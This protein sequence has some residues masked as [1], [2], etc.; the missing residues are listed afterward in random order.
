MKKIL[1]IDDDESVRK[2]LRVLLEGDRFEVI[3]AEDAI[4]GIYLAKHESPDLILLDLAIPEMDGIETCK[5]IKAFQGLR[6]IPIVMISAMAD[7]TLADIALNEGAEDYI[8]KSFNKDELI[9]K[10]NEYL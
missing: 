3:D 7:K 9:G 4:D 1:V 10:I 8:D 5:R 6:K 2:M